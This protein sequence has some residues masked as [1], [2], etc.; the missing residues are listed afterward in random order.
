[1]SGDGVPLVVTDVNSRERREELNEAGVRNLPE[2]KLKTGSD[3]WALP[4]LA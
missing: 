1:M 3:S 4:S 2:G